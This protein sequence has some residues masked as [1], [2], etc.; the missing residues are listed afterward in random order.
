MADMVETLFGPL[1]EEYCLF[2]YYLSIIS[3][4]F[5]VIVILSAVY[6]L[7][8][9]KKQNGAFFMATL[10]GSFAYLIVYFQNRLLNSMC[11]ASL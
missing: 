3:F 11:R 1:G 4:V 9:S 10:S 8:F 2:F 6:L 5:F 7:V